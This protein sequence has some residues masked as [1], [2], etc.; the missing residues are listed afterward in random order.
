MKLRLFQRHLLYIG[1]LVATVAATFGWTAYLQAVAPL[2]V[3]LACGIPFL[4]GMISLGVG[5][6]W[7]VAYVDEEA[8]ELDTLGGIRSISYETLGHAAPYERGV[9]RY[10]EYRVALSLVA[11]ERLLIDAYRGYALIRAINDAHGDFLDAVEERERIAMAANE[12]RRRGRDRETWLSRLR[13]LRSKGWS[14][15]GD[16]RTVERGVLWRVL[17]SREATVEERA[18]AA[19]ALAPLQPGEERGRL[20]VAAERIAEPR[21]RIALDAL[22]EPEP[23]DAALLEA[24]AAAEAR[25]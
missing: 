4:I 7:G 23:T 16:A 12:L 24:L 14:Y 11:G 15:R 5:A 3:A 2:T 6:M 17:E 19:V 20:R 18:G 8:L 21:L 13:G 1:F 9:G 10:R 22:G 25:Q